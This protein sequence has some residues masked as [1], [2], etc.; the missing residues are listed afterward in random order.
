MMT[1]IGRFMFSTHHLMIGDKDQLQ[2]EQS[3]RTFISNVNN[4]GKKRIPSH[5]IMVAASHM[6]MEAQ[7]QLAEKMVAQGITGLSDP[8]LIPIL[9]KIEVDTILLNKKA[10]FPALL[11]KLDM[12]EQYIESDRY[13]G[14]PVNKLIL[15]FCINST[16]TEVLLTKGGFES[17]ALAV[18][19][20]SKA[21]EL[22]KSPYFQMV[23]PVVICFFPSII[24]AHLETND[25]TNIVQTYKALKS[26]ADRFTVGTITVN[27]LEKKLGQ[28]MLLSHPK[29]T[30]KPS[31]QQI[32]EHQPKVDH[33]QHQLPT[34]LIIKQE[35][36]VD[37]LA[38]EV[39]SSDTE[40]VSTSSSNSPQQQTL[41]PLFDE[42]DN[43]PETDISKLL[44]PITLD[45]DFLL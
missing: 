43:I 32:M 9:L 29:S 30:T 27:S 7:V 26:V 45:S 17:R 15:Q 41:D 33:M 34:N 10:D 24:N 19:S 23:A 2:V 5:L 22:T 8:T 38:T 31:Y 37:I 6:V 42:L 3:V 39:M 25:L 21:T 1:Y 12:V 36:L 40:S 35:P 28:R 14:G 20:A 44:T 16:R 11:K 18:I 13:L 4:R